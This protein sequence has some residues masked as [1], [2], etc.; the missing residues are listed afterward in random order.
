MKNN[1]SGFNGLIDICACIG[2]SVARCFQVCCVVQ[3]QQPQ[4]PVADTV[5]V[6]AAETQT[7]SSPPSSPLKGQQ[8]SEP[9]EDAQASR[10]A[11]RKSLRLTSEQIVSHDAVSCAVTWA[12]DKYVM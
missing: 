8:D 11:Y 7:T 12:V 9:E 1:N 5:E 10:P 6:T 2:T 3:Q 4:P